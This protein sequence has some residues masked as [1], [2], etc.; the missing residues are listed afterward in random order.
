MIERIAPMSKATVTR[1]FVGANVAAMVGLVVGVA[2]VVAALA[3]GVVAI[4]GPAVVAVD[5]AAVA[6]SLPW[7]LIAGLVLA[8]GVIAGVASWIGALSNTVGL[9][10]RTWFIGLLALGLVGLGWVAMVAY[11]IAGPDRTADAISDR[12]V[13]APAGRI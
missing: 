9:D 7:L 3:G 11:V 6:G 5:G 4:G 1:L 13:A 10:D 8:A 2:T 12:G